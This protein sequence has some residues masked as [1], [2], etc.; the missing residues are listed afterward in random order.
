MSDP[1]VINNLFYNYNFIFTRQL[2]TLR[3]DRIIDKTG[4]IAKGQDSPLM[5]ENF[6]LEPPHDPTNH[7]GRL[8]RG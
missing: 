3:Q 7:P 5:A 8:R 2:A 1:E 6:V 4:E